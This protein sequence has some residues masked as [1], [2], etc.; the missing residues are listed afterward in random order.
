MRDWFTVIGDI[1]NGINKSRVTWS[2]KRITYTGATAPYLATTI[3]AQVGNTGLLRLVIN[4]ATTNSANAKSVQVKI[5][6]VT[7]IVADIDASTEKQVID[8]MVAGSGSSLQYCSA[9]GASCTIS[10]SGQ[11]S[12]DISGNSTVA[13][14]LIIS[15]SADSISLESWALYAEQQ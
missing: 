13:I 8:V 1:I 9:S 3:S 7:A 6:D 15:D 5:N 11:T 12:I 14:Y 2:G 4:T 10:Q